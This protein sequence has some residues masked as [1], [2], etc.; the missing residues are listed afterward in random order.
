[1]VIISV[2]NYKGGVGK[3]TVTANLAAE[4]AHRGKKILTIDLD[5]QASLTFSFITVDDWRTNYEKAKTIKNWYDAFIDKDTELNLNN[6]IAH[7]K[8]ANSGKGNLD[9]ICSHLA[10]IILSKGVNFTLQKL[11]IMKIINSRPGNRLGILPQL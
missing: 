4:L 10:L 8:R 1:M 2:I 11:P 5:P 9:L 7:P 6:L 3:T